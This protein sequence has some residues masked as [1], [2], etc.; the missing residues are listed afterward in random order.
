MDDDRSA[1]LLAG[2]REIPFPCHELFLRV[3]H[4][5]KPD[6]SALPWQHAQ[7]AALSVLT[8][9]TRPEP[10]EATACTFLE[11]QASSGGARGEVEAR[12]MPTTLAPSAREVTRP[13]MRSVATKSNNKHQQMLHRNR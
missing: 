4:S 8:C 1:A 13:S 6:T 5:S 11:P 10:D 12:T 3:S 7:G 2:R 9:R